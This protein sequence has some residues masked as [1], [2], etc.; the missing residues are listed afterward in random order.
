[1]P[2]HEWTRVDAGIFHD[3]HLGWIAE[4][5][6]A[7]NSGL[8]PPDYYARAEQ[9]AGGLGPDVLTL[10][11]PGSNARP[12]GEPRGGVALADAPPKV[13]YHARAEMAQYAKK[14]NVVVIRHRSG[15]EVIAMVEL[16]SPGNK[17]SQRA[18]D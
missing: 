3:F 5:R 13:R 9:F 14:A 8:L 6:R 1:M 18:L 17:S 7:L 12:I 2:I 15:H 4:L 11:A 10:R 16:V